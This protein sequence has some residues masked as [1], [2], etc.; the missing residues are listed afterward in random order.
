MAINR[1]SWQFH[2]T[3]DPPYPLEW[4]GHTSHGIQDIGCGHRQ[5][6]LIILIQLGLNPSYLH[7]MAWA[8]LT[9]NTGYSLNFLGSSTW[10]TTFQ[11]AWG[12]ETILI[13]RLKPLVNSLLS[14]CG[15][16]SPTQY[17]P[18]VTRYNGMLYM[19]FLYPFQ[20]LVKTSQ[21]QV[22]FFLPP[23]GK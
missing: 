12:S 15:T 3:L 18:L 2:L 10:Y 19:Q 22:H 20:G 7:W 6:F 4:I 8:L 1:R 23:L 13:F 21:H 11:Q 9:Q 16:V 17:R 5:A 14:E